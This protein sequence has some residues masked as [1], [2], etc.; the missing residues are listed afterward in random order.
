MGFPSFNSGEVLTATDMNAVGLWLIKTQTVGTA[1]AT[2]EV[3][4]VF[5]S[6]YNNYRIVY[7]GG[8]NSANTNLNVTFGVGT[9]W[10]VTNYFGGTSY[11]NVGGGTWQLVANNGGASFIGGGAAAFPQIALDVYN[12]N[13]ATTTY[14]FGPYHRLDNGWIGETRIQQ[15]GSTQFTSFRI[16]TGAGTITGG[17]IRVYGFRS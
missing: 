11:I 7:S 2:V 1:V 9:T 8:T 14:A 16:Q 5:S 4:D 13:L 10:T 15:A 3:T 6:S 17:T 12:P